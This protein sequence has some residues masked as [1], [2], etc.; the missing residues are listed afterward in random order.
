MDSNL[1]LHCAI[2]Q[3]AP[4]LV[5]I[6]ILSTFQSALY[7]RNLCTQLRVPI[8]LKQHWVH[9]RLDVALVCGPQIRRWDI[10][11]RL[12]SGYS[13]RVYFL[14]LVVSTVTYLPWFSVV[15]LN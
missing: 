8:L 4:Y 1:L 7:H 15:V 12:R 5:L 3:Q 2:H 14:F 10:G 13:L 9:V 6:L 11:H